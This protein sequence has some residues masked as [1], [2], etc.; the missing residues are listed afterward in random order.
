MMMP[1]RLGAR[2]ALCA[3]LLATAQ[4]DTV[5]TKDQQTFK[6]RVVSE[7]KDTLV[8]RSR[9]GDLTIPKAEIK[10]HQRA[11]YAVELKDGSKVIG[12]IVGETPEKL[13]LK[14]D[15]QDRALAQAD[16]KGVAERVLPDERK[17]DE[18]RAQA[19]KLLQEKKYAEAIA[20][21]HKILD[22]APDD[23]TSIYNLACG[24]ALTNEKEKA[25]AALRRSL[26]AGFI[27]FGHIEVD[28]DW[29][30][31][32][33]DPGFKKLMAERAKFVESGVA[34]SV[35]R[36]HKA[37][38]GRGIEPK[39]YKTLHDKERNFVYMHT[40]SDADLAEIRKSLEQYG[41]WQWK[42]LLQNRPQDPIYIV[43]LSPSDTRKVFPGGAGGFFNAG[44]NVLLC[45]D[46]PAW[47][48]TRTSVVMHE[49]TH[50]LHHADMAARRQS[51]PIWLVEGL[52]TLFET[53]QLEAGQI[54]PLHSQRLGVIQSAI[55]AKRHIPWANLMAMNHPQFMQQAI[56]A[57]AQARYM[58]FY[59][60]EKGL[61]KKFY[62]EY[63]EKE[64]YAD[65]K[66]ALR[67][68]EVVF[69][70]PIGEVERD[71]RQWVLA[72]KVPPV[73]FL[74]IRTKE[75]AQKLLVEDVTAKSPADKAGIRKGDV[76]AAVDGQAI[77]N[78]GALLE[79]IGAKSVGEELVVQVIR[80]GKPLDL[81][82]K[83]AARPP[84]ADRP[85]AKPA[86]QAAFL[87]AS[88]EEAEGG[89]VRIKDIT[90]DSPAAKAGLQ[91]GDTVLE[92]D[93][94]PIGT[95]RQFLDAL[96]AAKPD[97]TIKLAIQRD[98]EKTTLEVKLTRLQ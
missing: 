91:P 46:I 95:V 61:L 43:L 17:L 94:K 31:M 14:V 98:G 3:A 32:R 73:P 44:S 45:G 11:S 49:F 19:L 88:V 30:G 29:D 66:S 69:G 2:A 40:R 56:I 10:E 84:D 64:S 21:Y 38:A 68:V 33:D 25:V 77:T 62:D 85:P 7:E 47:K 4:A 28:P 34:L 36:V 57:Y 1:A 50:A 9:F 8:L 78:Q 58:L 6:G 51:H 42:N 90:K 27:K 22:A 81:K 20:L 54:V 16:V 55:R 76:V 92:L 18:M 13:L 87:G 89:A 67:T 79:A 37:L 63:T 52:A 97:Q 35:E 60:L 80:E 65:D 24:Y 48:L 15:G 72:Q 74:G 83:L 59:M 70:K 23:A 93:G 26:E 96:K 86:P 82:V 75:E 39:A 71:W 41:E 12:Q 5:T 53:A